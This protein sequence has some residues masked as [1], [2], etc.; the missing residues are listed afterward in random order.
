MRILLS[1][2][3]SYS[4]DARPCIL[5]SG[6]SVH[7]Q[8]WFD[9]HS[10]AFAGN[11]RQGWMELEVSVHAAS[12]P[13]EILTLTPIHHS[14]TSHEADSEWSLRGVDVKVYPVY[15]L[16]LTIG[17]DRGNLKSPIG[18]GQNSTQ[19][20]KTPHPFESFQNKHPS[21]WTLKKKNRRAFSANFILATQPGVLD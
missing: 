4:L 3:A 20:F 8:T 17:S 21:P 6:R 13:D 9:D 14:N 19:I 12:R 18:A 10:S 11:R 1:G 16:T 7:K 2:C 5:L 15:K